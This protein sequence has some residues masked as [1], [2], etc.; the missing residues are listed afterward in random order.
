[1]DACRQRAEAILSKREDAL[2]RMAETLLEHETL[3]RNQ[4]ER[5][6]EGKPLDSTVKREVM[7][8]Q[9]AG[10]GSIVK[11]EAQTDDAETPAHAPFKDP[12]L[13]APG[14]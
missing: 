11:E 8:R 2:H 5:V 12:P 6:I 10:D 13:A 1:M 7:P 3:D 4:M 14:V 9:D